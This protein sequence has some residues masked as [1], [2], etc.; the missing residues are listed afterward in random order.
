[1]SFDPEAYAAFVAAYEKDVARSLFNLQEAGVAHLHYE[2]FVG[3]LAA[4]ERIHSF[5]GLDG[6]PHDQESLHRQNGDD[7]LARFENPEAAEP[8]LARERAAG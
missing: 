5:L 7:L 2:D 6:M 3:N 8:W 4:L 1:M